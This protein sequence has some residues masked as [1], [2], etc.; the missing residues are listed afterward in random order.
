M[1]PP[2]FTASSYR[3]YAVDF[4]GDGRRDLL[5][6][7][8]DGIGSVA[9]YLRAHGWKPRQA[10]ASRARITGKNYKSLLKHG[11]RLRLPLRRL[12]E[13]GVTSAKDFPDGQLATLIALETERRPEYWIGL[14]NFHVLIRYN[15]STLYAMAVHQLSQEILT[16]R[17]SIKPTGE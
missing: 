13:Y 16:A 1:G 3:R 15:P 12:R 4:N 7:I 9:N 17:S 5:H 11:P 10:V 14:H 6:N 8:A 2:Q